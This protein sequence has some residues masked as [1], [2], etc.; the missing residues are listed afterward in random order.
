MIG[1]ALRRL[2]AIAFV[3][4]ALAAG[5]FLWF[6]DSSLVAVDTVEV[7][8]LDRSSPRSA[9][10]REALVA[11]GQGLST[12]DLDRGRL[13]EALEPYPE[14]RSIEAETSFPGSLTVTVELHRPVA[15]IGEGEEAVGVAADG[16]VLPPSSIADVDLPLMPLAEPPERGSLRGPALEQV[17]VLGGAPEE[18]LS[19]SETTEYREETGPV[20][21]LGGGIELRFGDPDRAAEK[22]TA[23]AAVLT[24]P[25]LQ[26]LDYVDVSSPRRPSVG[27][28]GHELPPIG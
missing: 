25:E 16:T 3:A 5:Y 9:R 26:R 27:G 7:V 13:R 10:M 2:A 19:V 4:A 12:L 1:R 20:V 21:V 18:L 14:V 11:A 8:G 28:E 24:D 22:W 6:E 17:Q 15:R 23:A